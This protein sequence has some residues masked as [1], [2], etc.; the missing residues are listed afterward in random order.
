[1]D[2]GWETYII[3]HVV[4]EGDQVASIMT[5]EEHN[6]PT[7]HNGNHTKSLLRSMKKC[8]SMDSYLTSWVEEIE[9]L[10]LLG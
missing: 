3:Y 4:K 8:L 1:M 10:E 5:L 7:I 6:S 2:E 9:F